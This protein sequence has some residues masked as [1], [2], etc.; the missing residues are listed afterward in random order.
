MIFTEQMVLDTGIT[1][2]M[3]ED[4]SLAFYHYYNAQGWIFGSGL[5]I[6]NLKSAMWRWK[7]NGYRFEKKEKTK[8]YPMKGKFCG[9][10][11][12]GRLCGMPA[13]YKMSGNYDSYYCAEDMPEKVKK[14]YE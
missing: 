6:V 14:L 3:P 1:L 13:V 7:R 10:T 2:G 12:N 4:K 9:K 11:R 8:L 5:E